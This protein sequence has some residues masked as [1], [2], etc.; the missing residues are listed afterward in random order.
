[1]REL[2]GHA[3]PKFGDADNFVPSKNGVVIWNF[4]FP[5]LLQTA[6]QAVINLTKCGI[7]EIKYTKMCLAA[8]SARTRWESLS[9]L[10][11]LLISREEG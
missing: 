8:G 2:E 9:A 4:A 6:E 5:K 10:P 3:S 1:M 7:F 11:D